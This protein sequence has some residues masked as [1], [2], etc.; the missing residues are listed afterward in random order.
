MAK[1]KIPPV[2][3]ASIGEPGVHHLIWR[4]ALRRLPPVPL[5]G[6]NGT[7][8][9]HRPDRRFYCRLCLA[10]EPIEPKRDLKLGKIPWC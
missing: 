10:L 6:L 3:W 1:I 9:V 8:V 5:C 7:A 4:S 2:V